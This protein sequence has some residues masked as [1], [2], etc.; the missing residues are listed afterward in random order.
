MKL[1]FQTAT[2]QASVASLA[3]PFKVRG[4]LKNPKVVPDALGA[5]SGALGD[6]GSVIDDVTGFVSGLFGGGSSNAAANDNPCGERAG[7]VQA[8][9]PSAV[10]SEPANPAPEP[11]TAPSGDDDSIG[12]A[13]ENLKKDLGNI[14]DLFE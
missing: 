11:N 7:A 1:D 13:L 10:S 6:G 12:N 8:E 9:E 4:T 3:I 5:A 14:G 2:R